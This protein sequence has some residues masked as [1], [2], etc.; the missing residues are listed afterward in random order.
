MGKPSMQPVLQHADGLAI[1]S[2]TGVM[3]QMMAVLAFPPSEGCRMRVS[4]ESR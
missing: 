3:A 1:A 4:L 2:L